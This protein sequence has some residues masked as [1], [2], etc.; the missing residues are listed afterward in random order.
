MILSDLN[1]LAVDY[2]YKAI[3]TAAINGFY[4]KTNELFYSYAGHH[5]VLIRSQADGH[6]THAELPGAK[7]TANLPLGVEASIPYDQSVMSLQSGDLLFLYTDGLVEARNSSREPFGDERL[8]TVLQIADS[9]YQQV[10]KNV[11]QALTQHIQDE[12]LHDDVT[13]MAVKIR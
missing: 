7:S 10:K 13:F 11:L 5:P 4:R 6:W 3:T 12:P 1:R 2:G 9:N 8:L